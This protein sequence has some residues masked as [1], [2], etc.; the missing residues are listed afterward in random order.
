[1]K[2]F[3]IFCVVFA[4][5]FV[6]VRA[7]GAADP[8]IPESKTAENLYESYSAAVY[9]VQVIDRASDRKSGIGSGF[10]FTDD[11]YMA[12]NYHVVAG[13]IQRP[14]Q[15]RIEYVSTSG[16]KGRLEVV[17]AD[18]VHDLAIVKMAT[19]G[20]VYVD[21]GSTDLRNGTKIYAFGNPHDIGFTIMEGTY[22]GLS[23]DG[24]LEKIHFSGSLNGG[25]SGGPT[26]TPSGQVIGINV[27]TAGNQISFL[28]PVERLKD[29]FERYR[30]ALKTENATDTDSVF[31]I[32]AQKHL[33][34]QLLRAQQK[35][36][37]QLLNGEWEH[38][39]FGGMQVPG[40][41]HPAFKCWGDTVHQEKD[42]YL[43]FSST[44]ST[45]EYIYL[46]DDFT[47]GTILY[48]YDVLEAKPDFDT[49]RFYALYE[50][51]YDLSLNLSRRTR[52]Q[53]VTNYECETGFVT[54]EGQK[55]KSSFCVR[56]YK[57]YPALYDMHLYMARVGDLRK[58]FIVSLAAEGVSQ[59]NALQL[60]QKFM[61][62]VTPASL[63]SLPEVQ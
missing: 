41:I 49:F 30:Q 6:C 19:A 43:Y 44:C 21:L 13:A 58:G 53:D 46:D 50:A 4:V 61:R 60:A 51:K 48:R 28:V 5:F 57:N 45:Q 1:M 27:S 59:E 37:S 12:T 9:Q 55:W 38:K 29:L 32:Q 11:G 8:V 39:V 17:A 2:R 42:P 63:V 3:F 52:E 40:R 18:V 31:P 62:H 20:D 35:N 14:D 26:L 22:N 47:T 36:I 16:D 34:E 10:Q 56:R 33:Q 7:G 54:V 15:N 23:A 24:F 25:M